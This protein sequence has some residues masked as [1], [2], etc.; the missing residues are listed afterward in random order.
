MDLESVIKSLRNE[1]VFTVAL[2]LAI[3][4]SFIAIP[5]SNYIDFKVLMSLF[6]LMLMVKAFEELKIM[7]K[8]AVKI[9][10]RYKS[11]RSVSLILV[12]LTFVSSMFVTNDVAL[13]TFVPLALII[14]KKAKINI[15]DTIIFQTLAANIGSSLTPMGNPQNL[16]LFSYYNLHAGEFFKVTAPFVLIG[17]LWLFIINFKIDNITLDFNLN[18][19]EVEDRKKGIIYGIMFVIIIMS[20]FNFIDYKMVTIITIIIVFIFNKELIVK[21]DYF[22]LATFIGFFIFI[23]NVSDSEVVHTF[24]KYFLESEE[25]TY[26]TALS[27]SQVVSNVPAAILLAGFT[28]NWREAL[29]G[30][31]IGGMGTLIASLASVIS[32]KLYVTDFPNKYKEYLLKFSIYN[33]ISLIIFAGINYFIFF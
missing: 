31:N 1:V 15:M 30:V 14:G 6:N 4:T 12:S 26:F 18:N 2:I 24:M 8:L 28:D 13:I 21:I 22:L 11:S 29:L 20:I 27:V 33:F 5:S 10:S 19:I 25:K 3:G 9:L 7:D 32:Y 17:G 16:F 23:G